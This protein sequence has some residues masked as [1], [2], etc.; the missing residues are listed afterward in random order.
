MI[1]AAVTQIAQRMALPAVLSCA[2]GSP[3]L[4]AASVYYGANPAPQEF[5]AANWVDNLN[6]AVA[7][8]TAADLPFINSVDGVTAYPYVNSAVAVQ[9]FLIADLTADKGGLEI[10]SGGTVTT[11]SASAHY[12]GARGVGHLR[13]L[14]SGTLNINGSLQV[15]WGDVNGRGTGMVTQSGGTY[16]GTSASTSITLGLSAAN[17]QFPAPSAGTYNM[18]GGS[19]LLG[20]Q[21]VVGNAGVG[22][23][24]M[25]AGTVQV[26]SYL[27]IARTGVGTLTQ[28]GGTMQIVRS[29]GDSMVIA[30]LA[31]ANGSYAISGGSLSVATLDETGGVV[32]GAAT[33]DST[34]LFKVVGN[35]PSVTFTNSVIQHAGATLAFEIGAGISPISVGAAATLNGSLDVDFSTTPTVGQQF[36]IMSYGS[37]TGTFA[38]FDSLVDSPAGPDTVKLSIDYGTGSGSQILVKVDSLVA[39][40]IPGDFN[41]DGNVDATDLT[42][43]K[44]NYPI[45]AGAAVAQGDANN[46]AAVDGADFLVWQRNFTGSPGGIATIPEP[47]AGLLLMVGGACVLR[48]KRQ[49]E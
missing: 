29:T 48:R 33:G 37:L 2:I 18:N 40:T 3:A 32:F 43:W 12:V 47:A 28:T 27:Q 24:N 35:A 6:A 25:S 20:G 4:Q 19:M 16:N 13:I 30:P 7:A 45:A 17:A 46:D 41:G 49:T 44:N 11:S 21:L 5:L 14:P 26:G 38:S 36:A 42:A 9:R 10:R 15:G 22:T 1:Q 39:P 34:A 8:P 23:F 31:G